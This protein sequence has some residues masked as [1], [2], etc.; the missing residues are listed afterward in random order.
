MSTI[1]SFQIALTEVCRLL[2]AGAIWPEV[3]LRLRIN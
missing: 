3:Q 2:M 1:D